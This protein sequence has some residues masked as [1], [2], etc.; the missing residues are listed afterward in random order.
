MPADWRRRPDWS[1][2]T[3]GP[4]RPRRPRCREGRPRTKVRHRPAFCGSQ[5]LVAGV[6]RRESRSS[7]AVIKAAKSMSLPA[8]SIRTPCSSPADGRGRLPNTYSLRDSSHGIAPTIPQL[9]QAEVTARGCMRQVPDVCGEDTLMFRTTLC[10]AAL[11]MG[12]LIGLSEAAPAACEGDGCSSKPLNIMQF[13]REQAASTRVASLGQGAPAELYPSDRKSAAG[14]A[15]GDRG[16]E[17]VSPGARWKPPQPSHRRRSRTPS[18]RNGR[19]IQSFRPPRRCGSGRNDG[20]GRSKRSRSS[21]GQC[22]GYQRHRSQG[23]QHPRPVEQ[24]GA[25]RR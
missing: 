6:K 21:T 1:P 24:S 22:R 20:R 8:N 10:C 14:S 2:R 23:R 18:S 17:K 7:A 5:E 25:G 3:G 16:A 13:M 4:P 9:R 12:L 19:A 11:A 15:P